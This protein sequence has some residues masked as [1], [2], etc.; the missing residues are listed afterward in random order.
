M[1]LNF[2]SCAFCLL[3]IFFHDM[4]VHVFCTFSNWIACLFVFY[5]LNFENSL[6]M[7]DAS[8]LGFPGGS[9]GKE[10][11]C[12]AGDLTLIPGLGRSPGQRSWQPTPVFLPGESSWAEE[13]G[14]LQSWDDK[15]LDTTER[16]ST[17][18]T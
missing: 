7:L 12:R 18:H 11:A 4:S 10:S 3:Y 15:E 5:S 17:A 1:I 14:G 9:D 6:Y 8:H 16:L 13:P 2:F